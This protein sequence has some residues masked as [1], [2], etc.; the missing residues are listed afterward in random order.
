M[1]LS[2]ATMSAA[3]AGY[4]GATWV[5]IRTLKSRS[6]A[7]A[8][9]LWGLIALALVSHAINLG[10][11]IFYAGKVDFELLKA[12]SAI[13]WVIT[14]FISSV[15]IRR[16]PVASLL[17]L[18][19]PFAII[20]LLMSNLITGLKSDGL[21]LEPAISVHILTSIFAYSIL[22]LA[23]VQAASISAQERALKQHHLRGYAQFLPPLQMMEEMLFEL[24]WLGV[25]LL[26]ISI[27]TGFLFLHD[28]L[29]QHVAHKTVF[30]ICAW[31][32]FSTLLWGRHARG[33]RGKTA[34]RFTLVGFVLM[35]LAYFG[36]KF[37]LEIIL[38]R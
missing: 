37:V 27:G 26:T 25:A 30:S 5:E 8:P 20:A 4:A 34:V 21:T 10:H 15:R 7:P 36:S 3:L 17:I 22:S 38:H 6:A 31:I 16:K 2:I 32:I 18:T 24:L 14:A 35:M 23:A 9:W 19:F 28:M 12:A 1:M 33:W 13:F 29:G 11:L